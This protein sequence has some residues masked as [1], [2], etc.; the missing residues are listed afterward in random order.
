MPQ[1]YGVPQPYPVPVSAPLTSVSV[2]S[3][4]ISLAHAGSSLINGVALGGI[5]TLG[6]GVATLGHDSLATL[7]HGGLTTLGSS[8]LSL[9]TGYA[10]AYSSPILASSALKVIP[11][12]S[13]SPLHHANVI[14]Y[15][16]GI[17][18]G[19]TKIISS[20]L[21]YGFSKYHHY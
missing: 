4:G 3:P 9:G 18:L 14:R 7:A 10:S 12:P 11:A 21:K 19:T 1:P 16:G 5:S 20:P 17:S 15:G 8:A 6:H 2:S 13:L